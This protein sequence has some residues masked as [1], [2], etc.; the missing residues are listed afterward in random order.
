MWRGSAE[1]GID[2]VFPHEPRVRFVDDSKTFAITKTLC[3][4]QHLVGW[5]AH[6]R[7]GG[8]GVENHRGR[9]HLTGFRI[10][11]RTLE[12]ARLVQRREPGRRR[13]PT[14]GGL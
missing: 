2:H 10:V 12:R 5:L 7:D 8:M 3:L 6:G 4:V 14:A 9:P 1:G 13:A 11:P